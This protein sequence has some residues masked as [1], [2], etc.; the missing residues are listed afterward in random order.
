MSIEER[1]KLV[2]AEEAD[3]ELLALISKRAFDSDIDVGAPGPGGPPDYDSPRSHA[4]MM[5][6]ADYWEIL[7]DDVIIGAVMVGLRGDKH[8]EITGLFVDP[9]FH[10]QGIATR[11]FEIL[12]DDYPDVQLWTLGTP[13][14]NVRTKH[15]Y[16][17]LGFAQVGFTRDQNWKGRWYEKAINLDDPY[18]MMGIS[19]LRDGMR[20]VDVE[21]IIE[22]KAIARTVR[23]RRRGEPLT[24]SEATLRD[25]TGSVVLVL[26][27]EQI[28]QVKVGE[29]IRVENGYMKSFR[30]IRQLNVG[31]G[32]KLIILN[33]TTEV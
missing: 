21:G 25:E 13:E 22:E 27:N 33:D 12:W 8:A 29:K 7:L 5:S 2:K 31:R 19:E 26:W 6:I 20:N 1:V 23:G 11:V 32:G 17:K 15:F 24:V 30:G 3:A 10:N 16:E 14:W 9:E 18:I 28:R 4:Y